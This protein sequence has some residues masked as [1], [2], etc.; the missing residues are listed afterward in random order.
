MEEKLRGKGVRWEEKGDSP[1][2]FCTKIQVRQ[3]CF[4]SEDTLRCLESQ[5]VPPC[6]I[7]DDQTETQEAYNQ[8]ERRER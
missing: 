2:N 7:K 1:L 3:L 4:I 5:S 6:S 8:D